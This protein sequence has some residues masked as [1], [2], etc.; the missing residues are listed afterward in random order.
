MNKAFGLV[1]IKGLSTAILV[2]DTMAKTANVEICQVENSKGLGWMTIKVIGDVGAVNAAINAGKQVGTEYG[3]YVS[4]KVIPRPS[5]YVVKYFCH[6]EEEK[7]PDIGAADNFEVKEIDFEIPTELSLEVTPCGEISTE[8]EITEENT[9]YELSSEEYESDESEE[10]TEL[11]DYE[12]PDATHEGAD[13]A[14]AKA[15]KVTSKRSRKK[16]VTEP[17]NQQL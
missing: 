3:N 15:T 6:V 8:N 14:K 16:K 1:E 17:D 9:L 2:A 5:D 13:D 7:S 12:V 11:E 4:S 10:N